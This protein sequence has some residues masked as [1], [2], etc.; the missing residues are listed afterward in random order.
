[1]SGRRDAATL[2][3]ATAVVGLGIDLASKAAIWRSLHTLEDQIILIPGWLTLIRR[4]NEGGIWSVFHGLS[5]ANYWLATFSSIA[6]LAIFWLAWTVLRRGQ[7]LLPILLGAILGGAIGNLYDRML[8]GGVRDWISVDLQFY[9]WPT[10]NLAD[11]FLV[12]GAIGLFIHSIFVPE[13]S[14]EPKAT[15][16]PNKVASTSSTP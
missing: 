4:L 12:C 8:F 3:L 2:F 1:M 10:F 6:I 14:E 13:N 5:S 7:R 16:E 9:V 11:S 15:E